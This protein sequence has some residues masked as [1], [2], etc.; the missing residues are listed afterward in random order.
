M[1]FADFVTEGVRRRHGE[2]LPLAGN[3]TGIINSQYAQ[4]VSKEQFRASVV[5]SEKG[6]GRRFI[7]QQTMEAHVASEHS[8]EARAMQQ[9][10]ATG[11][12]PE[13]GPADDEGSRADASNILPVGVTG[14]QMLAGGVG[15]D[16][17]A[18]EE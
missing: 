17:G 6:C 7:D 9:A 2:V 12:E 5:C 18:D 10:L 11:A 14:T 16:D 1:V 13:K 8:L 4:Y 15:S 3:V